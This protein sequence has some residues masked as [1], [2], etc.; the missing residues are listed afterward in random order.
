MTNFVEPLDLRT[1][2][3]NYFAGNVDIFSFI[4][5]IALAALAAY[6]K[7][8][9]MIFLI[10]LGLFVVFMAAYMPG[11]YLLVVLGTGLLVFYSISQIIKR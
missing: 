1:I 5:V 2:L 8:P 7:M 6:F 11:L 9:D 4:S 10:M 3:V